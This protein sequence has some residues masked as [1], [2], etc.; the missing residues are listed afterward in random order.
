M[1][2]A[3][4]P[5]I[6][7]RAAPFLQPGVERVPRSEPSTGERVALDVLHPALHLAL[8]PGPIGLTRPRGI[9]I[10]AREVLDHRMP[11]DLAF[12]AAEDQRTRIVVQTGERHAPEV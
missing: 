6:R 1:G 2:G 5:L 7:D 10:V 11:P 12:P 3:M 9:P 4:H 8:R